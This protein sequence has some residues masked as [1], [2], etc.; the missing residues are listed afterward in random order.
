MLAFDF[1]NTPYLLLLRGSVADG[2]ED[3]RAS[4]DQHH[5]VVADPGHVTAL[6]GHVTALSGDVTASLGH[7]TALLGHVTAVSGH[8]TALSGHVTGPRGCQ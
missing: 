7:V 5:V 6:L 2:D 4:R 3:A 8:V 1:A